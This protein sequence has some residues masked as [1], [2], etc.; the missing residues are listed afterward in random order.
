MNTMPYTLP[1]DHPQR[2]AL[3][4]EVHARP[5]ESLIAPVRLSYLVVFGT[6]SHASDLQGLTELIEGTGAPKPAA[7]T[8]HY[9]AD[10]GP[11]RVRW[12]RHTEFVR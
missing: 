1:A 11:C 3:N 9:V 7:D 12:E 10:L 2:R 6:G 8:N 4:D 5:P